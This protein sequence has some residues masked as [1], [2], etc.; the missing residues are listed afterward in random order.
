MILGFNEAFT[1]AII[2]GTKVHTIREGFRWQVGEIAQFYARAQQPDKYVFWA[3]R[4]ILLIQHIELTSSTLRVDG[5]LL[6]AAELTA[7]AKADG[8]ATAAEL[9]AFFADKPMPFMGQLL[10]WTPLQY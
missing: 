9:L 1:P 5:R 6:D 8:F 10:H 2:A 7:L 4:P 3:P